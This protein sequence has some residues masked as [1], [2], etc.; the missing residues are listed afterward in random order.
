VAVIDQRSAF[1]QTLDDHLEAIAKRDMERFSRTLH[2][3]VRLIGPG[4][5]IIY[6]YDDA[7]AA[8]RG[9]FSEDGWTFEPVVQWADERS[10]AAWA[11]ASVR[12][13]SAKGIDRF[14]LLLLFV[15]DGE[16]WKLIYDQNTPCTNAHP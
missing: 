3:D 5:S 8:H 11:L 9:W 10:D 15:R 13:A 7:V 14:L 12:Y 6:G 2:R 16:N 4:G 1:R